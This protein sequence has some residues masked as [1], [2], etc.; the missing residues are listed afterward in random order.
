VEMPWAGEVAAV[1][2]AWFGGMEMGNALADVLF[3]DADPG[4]RLPTT[5]PARYRDHP[6]LF[7]Y[8]G[9]SGRVRYGEG[10]FMGYRGYAVR[11][12][13]PRFPFGHGLSYT[14]FAHRD[15]AVAVHDRRGTHDP[16]AARRPPLV[17]EVEVTVANTGDRPGTEVVQ[18]FVGP[19]P[20]DLA[21]PPLELKGFAKVRL[22]P[23]ESRAVS[24]GLDARAFAAY[25]PLL[26]GWRT[27]PG[28]HRFVVAS[29]GRPVLEVT[30]NVPGPVVLPVGRPPAT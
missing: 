5:F 14:T 11:G 15:L 19:P 17:A 18:L 6:A 30:A 21:R 10:V 4:G 23:G 1:V 2:Q 13:E 3:G 29:S 16:G 26:P 28:R 8:P 12:V 20:G 22:A 25:D 27:Q 9:E 7:G 24:L